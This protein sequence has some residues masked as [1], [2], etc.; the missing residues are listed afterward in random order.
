[1]LSVIPREDPEFPLL[2]SVG[3]GLL[4]PPAV[5]LFFLIRGPRD[6]EWKYISLMHQASAIVS[7][8]IAAIF[9]LSTLIPSAVPISENWA[10]IV[11]CSIVAGLQIPIVFVAR[12]FLQNTKFT[13]H[14]WKI[15]LVRTSMIFYFAVLFLLL[16]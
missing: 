3:I 15:A 12:S 4:L 2:A 14:N 8:S 6:I 11:F 13:K 1:M 5:G 16:K 7:G 10:L 9:L